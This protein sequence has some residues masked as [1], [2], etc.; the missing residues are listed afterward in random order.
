[1]IFIFLVA[2]LLIWRIDRLSK[3]VQ[4]VRDHLL[5][6]LGSEE[7]KDETLRAIEWEK[8]S[9][10]KSGVNFGFSG[11]SSWLRPLFGTGFSQR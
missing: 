5:I 10:G 6:E 11:V 1:L 3:Q 9:A 4:A 8:K 7:T 2:A